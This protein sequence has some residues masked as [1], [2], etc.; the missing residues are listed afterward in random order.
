MPSISHAY[1]E[2]HS[3]VQRVLKLSEA[4]QL[5]RRVDAT[6]RTLKLTAREQEVIVCMCFLRLHMAWETFLE[7]SFARYLCGAKSESGKLPV[8]LGGIKADSINAALKSLLGTQTYLSWNYDRSQFRARQ[9]FDKGV[10]FDF[11]LKAGA[12]TIKAMEIIR[13]RI[14]HRSTASRESLRKIVIQ[15]LT[16]LEPGITPGRLLLKTSVIG[17]RTITNFEDIALKLVIIAKAI[18]T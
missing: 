4:V 6:N 3:E 17:A 18:V 2:F 14:A 9:H 5:Y 15:W 16:F 12:S 7:D 13:N 8:I 10:P 1:N 11:P